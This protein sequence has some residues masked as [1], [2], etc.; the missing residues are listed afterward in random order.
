MKQNSHENCGKGDETGPFDFDCV[1]RDTPEEQKCAEAGCGFCKSSNKERKSKMKTQCTCDSI[2]L[3]KGGC[4]CGFIE[5]PKEEEKAEGTGS[6]VSGKGAGTEPCCGFCGESN[7]ICE[8][9]NGVIY[10]FNPQESLF[11]TWERIRKERQ[12]L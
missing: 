8:C 2:D 7:E 5:R 6:G 11:E 9:Y 3:F 1:H 4:L 12:K 10:D